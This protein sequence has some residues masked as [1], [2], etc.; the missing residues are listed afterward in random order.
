M[1][2]Q[3]AINGICEK[4]DKDWNEAQVSQ[5]A[6]LRMLDALGWPIFNPSI[7]F[8]QY[9][10]GGDKVDFALCKEENPLI[11]IEVKNSAIRVEKA[12][13]KLFGYGF[14]NNNI[15]LAVE[16]AEKQ[17]FR[18]VSIKSVSLAILTN[19]QNWKFY[20]PKGD[21]K[22]SERCF[23][24]L[25]IYEDSLEK[26]VLKLNR[27]LLYETFVSGDAFIAIEQGYKEAYATR[28]SEE[29]LLSSSQEESMMLS[30]VSAREFVGF[31]L[32][33]VPHHA[34][35]KKASAILVGVFNALTEIDSSFPQKFAKS[36]F[37]FYHYQNRY[38]YLS[39]NR[40]DLPKPEITRQLDSG[41]WIN[42]NLGRDEIKSVIQ[43]ACRIAKV[44]Y[45]EDLIL[46]L[47]PKL[48]RER[49]RS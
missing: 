46:C 28:P 32:N 42:F 1:S 23:C 48:T 34:K 44:I 40:N 5:G 26:C 43:G 45:G 41:W 19:G 24:D 47:P 25:S 2:L 21:G 38:K 17:L 37:N 14:E 13:A 18:Y 16:K 29:R 39:R 36:G 10:I 33:G 49:Q 27:Y 30:P 15:R 6:V 35:K 4:I 20:Y 7:V 3:Q 9:P 22:P 12:Q 8:P 31:V 11:Y